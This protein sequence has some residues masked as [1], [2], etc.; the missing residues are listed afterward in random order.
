MKFA[1]FIVVACLSVC[2]I[3]AANP[4]ITTWIQV[5]STTEITKNIVVPSS[6]LRVKSYT[7]SYPDVSTTFFQLFE[8][9]LIFCVQDFLHISDDFCNTLTISFLYSVQAYSRNKIKGIEHKDFTSNPATVRFLIGG[10]GHNNVTLEIE[11]QRGYGINSTF[12][13]YTDSFEPSWN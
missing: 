13:F 5:N 9:K 11:S 7:F 8:M 2:C 1:V 3:N 6:F 10:V 4:T 12:T